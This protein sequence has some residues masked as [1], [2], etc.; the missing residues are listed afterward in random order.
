M[1]LRRSRRAAPFHLVPPDLPVRGVRALVRG[2][3]VHVPKGT[4][5]RRLVADVAEAGGA[6]LLVLRGAVMSQLS[7][8]RC[9]K[10][11]RLAG[12]AR[13]RELGL[14]RRVRDKDDVVVGVAHCLFVAVARRRGGK[15]ADEPIRQIRLRCWPSR[16]LRVA[17][18]TALRPGGRLDA[19][20]LPDE[21]PGSNATL[22]AEGPGATLLDCAEARSS[23]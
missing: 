16:A 3:A 21:P 12:A 13:V 18:I 14:A 4:F 23:V 2:V 7:A 15:A 20:K 5:F 22:S 6:L 11:V 1:L 10:N 19:A 9:D 17:E 8:R